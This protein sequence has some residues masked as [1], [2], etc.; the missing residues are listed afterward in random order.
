MLNLAIL[1]DKYLCTK[2]LKSHIGSRLELA[3]IKCAPKFGDDHE[4][5]TE[6]DRSEAI[7]L[8]SMAMLLGASSAF[9]VLSS[10]LIYRNRALEW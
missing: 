1:A 7:R 5:F 8:L 9:R 10:C 3:A 4:P 6:Q 2:V